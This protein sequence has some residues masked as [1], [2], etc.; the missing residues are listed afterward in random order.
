MYCGRPLLCSS[1]EID[2]QLVC[3][4][5]LQSG[6]F[7][8]TTAQNCHT[9]S[10]LKHHMRIVFPYADGTKYKSNKPLYNRNKHHSTFQ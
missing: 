10:F 8:P 6:Y 9:R 3:L 7:R 1:H 5:G 4:P 2:V